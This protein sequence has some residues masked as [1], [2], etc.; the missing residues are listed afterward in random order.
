MIRIDEYLLNKSTLNPSIK[1][2]GKHVKQNI[3]TQKHTVAYTVK[4]TNETLAKIIKDE[5]EKQSGIVNL[6]HIDVSD[7]TDFHNVFYEKE[8]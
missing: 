6:N 8:N 7:V 3:K 4:A 2:K 1:L 5:F